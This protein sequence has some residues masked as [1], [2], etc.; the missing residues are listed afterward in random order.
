METDLTILKGG[1]EL[2][3]RLRPLWLALHEHHRASQPDRSF[4]PDELSWPLRRAE[5]ERW[6]AEEDSFVLV[7]ER[8]GRA[9][10]YA[11]VEVYQ[12]P[13]DTYATG[14]KVAE[15]QTLSVGPGE[16]GGGVGGALMDA[17]D[18]ELERLGVHDLYVEVLTGNEGAHR[19]YE[20][21]GL[22][23]VMAVY[24]RFRGDAVS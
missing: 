7:A 16:R 24:G 12:G 13:D 4:Q 21:R 17:M 20:R 23:P 9:V 2:L 3:D 19:F 5:Y 8:A 15:L 10:G 22:R 18:A 14:K 1:A 6:L 11:F